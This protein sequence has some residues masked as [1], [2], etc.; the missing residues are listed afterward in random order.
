M[1]VFE[2]GSLE[3]YGEF[4]S[5]GQIAQ[6][7]KT[8]EKKELKGKDDLKKSSERTSFQ[9]LVGRAKYPYLRANGV[10]VCTYPLLLAVFYYT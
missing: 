3:V 9:N 10:S 1:L 6:K 2:A 7:K 4:Y 8:E 5:L